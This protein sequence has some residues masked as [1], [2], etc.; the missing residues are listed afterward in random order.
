MSDPKP[1]YDDYADGYNEE[2]V[3]EW[4]DNVVTWILRQDFDDLCSHDKQEYLL[5]SLNLYDASTMVCLDCGKPLVHKSVCDWHDD[6]WTGGAKF[7]GHLPKDRF[8]ANKVE[9]RSNFYVAFSCPSSTTERGFT[10]TMSAKTGKWKSYT[11]CCKWE[12]EEE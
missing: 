8:G 7:Y 5:Y 2:A 4:H 10:V 12:S 9:L 1:D 11:G 3:D 6:W